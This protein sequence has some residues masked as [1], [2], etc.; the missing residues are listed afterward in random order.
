M[1]WDHLNVLGKDISKV[2]TTWNTGITAPILENI[3]ISNLTLVHDLLV[4]QASSITHPQGSLSNSSGLLDSA[5]Y[6]ALLS[7]Y[8]GAA[9]LR[10]CFRDIASKQNSYAELSSYIACLYFSKSIILLHGFWIASSSIFVPIMGKERFFVLDIFKQEY[11][12]MNKSAS[13]K[14]LWGVFINLLKDN[15]INNSSLPLYNFVKNTDSHTISMGRNK[16]QYD[17]SYWIHDDL[18]TD[19]HE[20]QQIINAYL[21]NR[22]IGYIDIYDNV[23]SPYRKLAYELLDYILTILRELTINGISYHH[24]HFKE[25]LDKMKAM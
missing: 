4:R 5:M 12:V 13:H 9:V 2:K 6:D 19:E 20:C 1:K 17:Y 11:Y 14:D 3:N 7:S 15:Y 18:F 21:P 8:K 22:N 10:S 25:Y 24:N 16:I 23:T